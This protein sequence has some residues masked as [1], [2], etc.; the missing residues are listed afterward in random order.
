V[1]ELTQRRID[2]GK[3]CLSW[4][5]PKIRDAGLPVP[6]TTILRCDSEAAQSLYRHFDGQP[7]GVKGSDFLGRV[8]AAVREMGLPCFLRTGQTSGKHSWKRTCH[9]QDVSDVVRHVLDLIEFSECADLMGLPWDMWAVREMLPTKPVMAAY[10][11]MPVC[12]EFRMFVHDGLVLCK[13]PYWPIVALQDGA[14]R[15]WDTNELLTDEDAESRG[16]AMWDLDDA[17]CELV[18]DLASRAG[19]ACGGRWSVDVLDTERGWFVT[20]MAVMDL[21]WHWPNCPNATPS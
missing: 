16:R 1:S 17:D 5:F 21:S 14:P 4:W 18:L 11:E 19:A 2:M 6:K 12:R 3:S 20:D 13:H 15:D 7:V 8:E 10:Q 9:I